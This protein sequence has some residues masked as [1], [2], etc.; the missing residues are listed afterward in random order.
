MNKINN[1]HRHTILVQ[2]GVHDQKSKLYFLNMH[3]WYMYGLFAKK[4]YK[5]IMYNWICAASKQYILNKGSNAIFS[6]FKSFMNER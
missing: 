4:T 3:S 2:A 6:L 5:L 1:E